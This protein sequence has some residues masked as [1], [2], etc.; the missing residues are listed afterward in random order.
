MDAPKFFPKAVVVTEKAR[1]AFEENYSG[2]HRG[3]K[4]WIILMIP[5]N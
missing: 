1:S 4:R 5:V 3:M 2:L